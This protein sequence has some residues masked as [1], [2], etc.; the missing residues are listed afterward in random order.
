MFVGRR[1]SV[2]REVVRTVADDRIPMAAVP[3]LHLSSKIL[4]Q[5]VSRTHV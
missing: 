4:G 3:M 5:T 2:A 1:G